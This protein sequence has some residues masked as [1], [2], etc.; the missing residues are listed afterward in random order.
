MGTPPLK[1]FQ[2]RMEHN[3][4]NLEKV[5]VLDKYLPAAIHNN[6]KDIV[7]RS[8]ITATNNYIYA[9]AP[10]FSGEKVNSFSDLK[11]IKPIIEIW[12]WDGDEIARFKLN[13]ICFKF[14]ASDKYKKLYAF[15]IK[16]LNVIYEYDLSSELNSDN[17]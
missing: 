15:S 16:K 6:K 9:Y 11:K 2:L 17:H 12:N 4:K 8:F 5:K 13:K 10:G 14:A 1:K 7:Y 3:R